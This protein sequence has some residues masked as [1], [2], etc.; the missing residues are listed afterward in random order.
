MRAARPPIPPSSLEITACRSNGSSALPPRTSGA[1]PSNSHLLRLSLKG[2]KPRSF[3]LP[4]LY[5]H[6]PRY[7]RETI[8]A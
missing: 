8:A 3:R 5:L 6:R 4:L 1:C 2:F 7:A